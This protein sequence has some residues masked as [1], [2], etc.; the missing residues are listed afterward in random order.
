MWN[1][2]KDLKGLKSV[3]HA[4]LP[5]YTCGE[6]LFVPWRSEH[7]RRIPYSTVRPA[8]WEK[9]QAH[10]QSGQEFPGCAMVRGTSSAIGTHGL[11]PLSL[12]GGRDQQKVV[13]PSTPMSPTCGLNFGVQMVNL[14]TNST[15]RSFRNHSTNKKL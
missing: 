8:T 7:V 1:D 9:K 4:T 15:S 12:S 6:L 13:M 5:R 2:L 14:A 3:G 11:K 10:V